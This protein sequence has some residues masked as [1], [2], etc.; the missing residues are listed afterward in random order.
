MRSFIYFTAAALISM[1]CAGSLSLAQTGARYGHQIVSTFAPVRTSVP[2]ARGLFTPEGLANAGGFPNFTTGDWI[3][4]DLPR[5]EEGGATRIA[6]LEA[7]AGPNQ[8]WSPLTLDLFAKQTDASPFQPIGSLVLNGGTSSGRLS[9][10]SFAVPPAAV[11]LRL[12][13]RSAPQGALEP[14]FIAV[15]TLLRMRYSTPILRHSWYV[16]APA[17]GTP[18]VASFSIPGF[19]NN[20]GLIFAA[21]SSALLAQPIRVGLPGFGGLLLDPN[22][23]ELVSTE[24]F[25]GTASPFRVDIYFPFD[26]IL[27][28]TQVH[29]QAA[30]VRFD[31]L[32]GTVVTWTPP[33]TF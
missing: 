24:V 22:A 19:N 10:T 2:E 27:L 8:N 30:L 11:T 31:P 20:F 18:A 6:Y 14:H 5:D 4:L 15:G 17:P 7:A 16:Q 26:P 13:A 3:E 9:E 12:V 1:S 23:T 32:L 21:H 33:V 29:F 25:G 28:T